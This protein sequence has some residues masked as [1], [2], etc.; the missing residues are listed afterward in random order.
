MYELS[1][2][3]APPAASA[4]VVLLTPTAADAPDGQVVRRSVV[5]TSEV[6]G[7]AVTVRRALLVSLRHQT[8]IAPPAYRLLSYAMLV[9]SSCKVFTA[10]AVIKPAAVRPR[11]V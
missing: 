8:V 6:Q 5:V 11:E 2:A 3:T 7:L 10:P 1:V 9:R 4:P